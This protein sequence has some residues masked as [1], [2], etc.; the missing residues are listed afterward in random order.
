[1]NRESIAGL[2]I[3]DGMITAAWVTTGRGGRKR[4]R[5]LGQA[6]YDRGIT[7]KKLAA[8]VQKLWRACRMPTYTV[9]SSMHSRSMVLKHFL[10]DGLTEAEIR[11]ALRLDAELV[12]GLPPE[13]ILT[14]W[15]VTRTATSPEGGVRTEG[16]L[17]AV[18][19]QDVE[20][21]VRL[22]EMADL[23][24]VILDVGCMAAANLCLALRNWDEEPQSICLVN[25]SSRSAD[26]IVF[27]PD[28]FMYPRTLFQR[29]GTWTDRADY[30]AESLV[31]A[32]RYCRYNLRQT[33]VERLLVTGSSA[34][35]RGFGE[36]L[37]DAVGLPLECWDPL[38]VLAKGSV[39]VRGAGGD[40]VKSGFALTT[41]LGLALRG[42]P[43]GHV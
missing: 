37:A 43:N 4:V 23:Y 18:P 22:L 7:S 21:H 36:Q 31:E 27:G 30:L 6:A 20:R 24:P 32:V 17:V 14:D 42:T 38:T 39:R 41:T 40:D 15:Q 29:S 8:T 13:D 35:T 28:S 19:R 11:S 26:I 2:S 34:G 1:M 25:A 3:Q 16:V 10:F 5:K 9:C 33:P 12:L